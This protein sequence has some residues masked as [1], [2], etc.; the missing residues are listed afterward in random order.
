VPSDLT[1]ASRPSATPVADGTI[2]ESASTFD[3]ADPAV[4]AEVGA[5]ADP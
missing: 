1:A 3:H 5:L 4:E 2:T